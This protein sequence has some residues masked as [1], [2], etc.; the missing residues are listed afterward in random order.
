MGLSK[1]IVLINPVYFPYGGAMAN[2]LRYF[3]TGLAMRD[4][5]VEVILSSFKY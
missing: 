2:F 1:R 4:N 5:L 3:C